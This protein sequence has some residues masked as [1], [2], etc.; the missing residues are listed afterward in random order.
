MN[1]I[2]LNSPLMTLQVKLASSPTTNDPVYMA[3]YYDSPNCLNNNCICEKIVLSKGIITDDTEVVVVTAPLIYTNRIIKDLIIQNTDTVSHEVSVIID[4]NGTPF[5]LWTITLA[6]GDTLTQQAVY[7]SDGELKTN[8]TSSNPD[9]WTYIQKEDTG[10]YI[11][12]GMISPTGGW[13]IR[14]KTIATGVWLQATGTPASDYAA[15]GWANRAAH[16]YDYL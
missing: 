13:K 6:P 1:D 5:T 7:N 11:Y 4:I 3:T 15:V 14:R 12:Y 2:V 8:S 9:V 16:T 10:T